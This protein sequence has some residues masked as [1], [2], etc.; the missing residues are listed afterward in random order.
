MCGGWLKQNLNKDSK[1]ILPKLKLSQF[2]IVKL[3]VQ[4]HTFL[5]LFVPIKSQFKAID[6]DILR[7]S[8]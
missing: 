7:L 8:H 3:K 4:A 1:N 5:S 2:V 6:D